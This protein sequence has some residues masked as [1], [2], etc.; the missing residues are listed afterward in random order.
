MRYPLL[1]V[2]DS[3]PYQF[4]AVPEHMENVP[5]SE[6]GFRSLVDE[7]SRGGAYSDDRMLS[8]CGSVISN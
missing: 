4:L 5:D 2:I 7:T 1:N 3:H 6:V 8:V